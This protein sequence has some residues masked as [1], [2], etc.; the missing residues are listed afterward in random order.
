M[1][2]LEITLCVWGGV[3]ASGCTVPCWVVPAKR[4]LQRV[5]CQYK[6]FIASWAKTDVVLDRQEHLVGSNLSSTRQVPH[7]LRNLDR[8]DLENSLEDDSP[9]GIIPIGSGEFGMW[10]AAYKWS[11]RSRRQFNF[12]TLSPANKIIASDWLRKT[13]ASENV[14]PS[15]MDKLLPV[16][17]VLT[18]V[19]SKWERDM[20]H[21][22]EVMVQSGEI[23]SAG[24]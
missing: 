19:M 16:A 23:V 1:P 7:F 6:K 13:M 14:R 9:D 22:E 3:L 21:A 17:I 10:K 2:V 24:R 5:R 20:H 12:P 15:Q 4:A 11:R 18:F 8:I